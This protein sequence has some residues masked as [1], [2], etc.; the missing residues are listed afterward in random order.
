MGFAAYT[1]G[2]AKSNQVNWKAKAYIDESFQIL[3][4]IGQVVL[5]FLVLCDQGLLALQQFL[6]RL[7]ELL[8]FSMFMI[9]PGDHQIMFTGLGVFGMKREEFFHWNQ[10]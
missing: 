10:W 2:L 4:Q 6:S 9:D 3:I 5:S 1:T 8:P 7:F